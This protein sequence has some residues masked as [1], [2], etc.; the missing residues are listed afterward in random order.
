MSELVTP[1]QLRPE[2]K[3]D[4]WGR[5]LLPDPESGRERAWTRATTFAKTISD[6]YGLGKWQ[7]RMVAKG[8]AT[9]ADLY[10]LAASTP[11]DDKA[12]FDKICGDAKEAAK[13]SSGANLGTALHAFTEQID[14]GQVVAV[15]QP[16][17]KDVA[18]YKVALADAGVK[19][20]PQWIERIVLV[21]TYGVAGTLDRIVTLPDGRRVIADVKTGK[22]LGYSWGEISVQLALYANATHMINPATGL[23]EAMPAVDQDT[24][25]AI[26][27]PI[28][29][30]RCDLYTINIV[31]G[32]ETAYICKIVREWRQRKD[33]AEPYVLKL[34][35]LS[36]L[37]GIAPSREALQALWR[38]HRGDWDTDH[39]EE[40]Q[41][42]L[43]FLDAVAKSVDGTRE[44]AQEGATA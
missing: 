20:H 42:R 10:A 14:A 7:E 15:P 17:D 4:R 2:P 33:I 35:S 32:W 28:G 21:P 22:D 11:V 31:A 6:M 23:P 5:Y 29:Q 38:E 36:Y 16:W 19:V 27:L 37:I 26:H 18:A 9:R 41:E 40:A 24:A 1:A 3:R 43:A 8:I 30:G 34:P 39:T 25:I 44:T 13:A 12:K